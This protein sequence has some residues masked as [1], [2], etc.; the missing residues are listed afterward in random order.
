[1]SINK[2][3][4][5]LKYVINYSVLMKTLVRYIFKTR[6]IKNKKRISSIIQIHLKLS[7]YINFKNS[8]KNKKIYVNSSNACHHNKNLQKL[9]IFTFYRTKIINI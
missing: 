5:I 9:Y 1:M 8:N 6:H 3:I 7:L 2:N 4:M